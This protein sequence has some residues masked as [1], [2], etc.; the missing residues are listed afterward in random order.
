MFKIEVFWGIMWISCGKRAYGQD[1]RKSYRH[2][3]NLEFLS[4][5][6][7]LR[8]VWVLDLSKLK[9]FC[10]IYS[11]TARTKLRAPCA[12]D[13]SFTELRSAPL[14]L[15]HLILNNVSMCMCLC[16]GLCVW[17]QVPVEA[18]GGHRS[19]GTR[20]TG[21]CELSKVDAGN[22]VLVPC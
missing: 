18:R 11:C 21:G 3:F 9:F 13:F 19:L 2:I 15:L 7:Y 1:G 10:L 14:C 20:I 5:N 16:V 8:L 6:L 12:S 4:N 22:Q 17:E